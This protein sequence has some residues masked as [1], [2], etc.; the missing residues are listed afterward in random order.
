MDATSFS[1]QDGHNKFQVAVYI[2]EAEIWFYY[3]Y[4][5]QNFKFTSGII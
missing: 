2:L 4:I 1:R 5:F 3:I